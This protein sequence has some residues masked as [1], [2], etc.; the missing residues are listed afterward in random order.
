MMSVGPPAGKPTT[1]RTG[2]FGYP[3]ADAGATPVSSNRLARIP[4]KIRIVPLSLGHVL[5]GGIIGERALQ[6]KRKTS[7]VGRRQRGL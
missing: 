1:M 4:Y 6:N 5:V 7:P 2:R 3:C